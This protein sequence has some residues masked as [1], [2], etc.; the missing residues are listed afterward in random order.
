MSSPKHPIRYRRIGEIARRTGVSAKAVR[1]YEQR[2]L[3]TPCAYSA[4][5]H[6]LYGAAALQ[7]LVQ[8]VTLRRCGL[9]LREIG[10]LLAGDGSAARRLVTE[11]LAALEQEHAARQRAIATLQSILACLGPASSLSL[12]ELL[13]TI[14]TSQ[15]LKVELAPAEKAKM[16]E[17]AEALGAAGLQEAQEAWPRLIAEVRAAMQAGTPPDD[18]HAAGLARRWH[19]LVQAA[20]GGDADLNR[21]I[22]GAWLAQPEAMAAQGMDAAMF[23][24]VGAAMAA[25][26]L[27]F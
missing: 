19:A 25:Q 13:E 21:K 24:Y 2:G 20:T 7:R 16:R 11:R 5:G 26:G 23:R 3:L 17:R 8:I 12:D 4:A 14:M 9:G 22:G 10:G 18:P 27:S 1:L 6:R 15:T